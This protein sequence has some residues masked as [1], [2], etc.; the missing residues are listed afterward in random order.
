[1]KSTLEVVVL[2]E[3][4]GARYGRREEGTVERVERVVEDRIDSAGGSTLYN[5]EN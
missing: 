5:V 4:V 1:L 2:S 3:V